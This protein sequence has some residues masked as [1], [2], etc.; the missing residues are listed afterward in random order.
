[1]NMTSSLKSEIKI[2][3]ELKEKHEKRYIDYLKKRYGIKRAN[4][5][6]HTY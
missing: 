2:Q 6:I 1:M 5:F 3:Y 4:N